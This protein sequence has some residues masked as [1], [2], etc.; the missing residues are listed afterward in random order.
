MQSTSPADLTSVPIH[1]HGEY[2]RK[3]VDRLLIRIVTMRDRYF[4]SGRDI[5]LEHRDG[6]SRRMAIHQESNCQSPKSDFFGFIH[7]HSVLHP[8]LADGGKRR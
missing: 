8:T 6:A 1:R 7:H 4:A 3:T 2:A 5:E